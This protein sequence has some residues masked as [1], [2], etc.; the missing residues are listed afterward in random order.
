MLSTRAAVTWGTARCLN[1]VSRG[2]SHRSVI[3]FGTRCTMGVSSSLQWVPPSYPIW[4]SPTHP[5]SSLP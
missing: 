1:I 5:P 4:S 3:F 2:L